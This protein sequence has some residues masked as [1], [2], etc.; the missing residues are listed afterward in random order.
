[1]WNAREPILVYMG[2]GVY[3]GWL[4]HVGFV[5]VWKCQCYTAKFP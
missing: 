5:G 1:M 3:N 4:G 2:G